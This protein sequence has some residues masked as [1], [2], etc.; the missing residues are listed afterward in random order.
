MWKE[1]KESRK[2][3]ET[4]LERTRSGNPIG[5]AISANKIWND[6]LRRIGVKQ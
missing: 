4:Q 2:I 5:D 3:A 6:H 1:R